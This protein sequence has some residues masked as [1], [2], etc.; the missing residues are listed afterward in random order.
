[1]DTFQVL[2]LL[3]GFGMLVVAIMKR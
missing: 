2:S 1:M 3:I